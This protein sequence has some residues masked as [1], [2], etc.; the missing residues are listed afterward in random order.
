MKHR[1]I[2]LL[3]LMSI[4][5]SCENN[6]DNPK[7]QLASFVVIGDDNAEITL[8]DTLISPPDR[9]DSVLFRIDLDSDGL[10]DFGFLVYYNYSPCLFFSNFRFD[11]LHNLAKAYTNDTIQTPDILSLGDTLSFERSWVSNKFDLLDASGMCELGGGDGIIHKYGNWFNIS[12]QYIGLLI[13][14]EENPIYGWI[15]LSV[16][17]D[18]WIHSLTIHEIGNKKAAYNTRY[19]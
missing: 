4:I 10:E 12:N 6:N 2:F 1:L 15:K 8:L 3:I 18:D 14:K 5:F 9:G 13:E 16:P 11:C 17:N 19:N 7:E